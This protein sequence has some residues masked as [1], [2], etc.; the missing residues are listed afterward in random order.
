[1]QAMQDTGRCEDTGRKPIR[2]YFYRVIVCGWFTV[3]ACMLVISNMP[4]LYMSKLM[5][6][7]KALTG[8]RH[9]IVKEYVI[10]IT[11]IDAKSVGSWRQTIKPKRRNGI[12]PP[13]IRNQSVIVMLAD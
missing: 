3:D 4:E 11:A 1:M 6:N 10:L 2:L 12:S 9:R 7:C 5:R 13:S 8:T